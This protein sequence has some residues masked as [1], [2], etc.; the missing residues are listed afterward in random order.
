MGLTELR[1]MSPE[2]LREREN[3][4]RESI[5]RLTMKRNGKRLEKPNELRRVRRELA[6][7]MTVASEKAAAAS[8]GAS[9]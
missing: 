5:G 8:D 9:E 1:E 6:Q 7:L 3:D 4:L 2:E